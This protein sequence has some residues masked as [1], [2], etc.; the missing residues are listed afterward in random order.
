[1]EQAPEGH[2]DIENQL[3]ERIAALEKERREEEREKEE[4]RREGHES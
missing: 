2:S 3:Y 1:M 4:G